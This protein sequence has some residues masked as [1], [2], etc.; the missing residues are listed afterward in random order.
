MHL[1]LADTHSSR[2]HVAGRHALH[3]RGPS[4][5]EKTP[6]EL[7]SRLTCLESLEIPGTCAQCTLKDVC[8]TSAALFL[9]FLFLLVQTCIVIVDAL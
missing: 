8:R 3:N 6:E 1:S 7:I 4:K 2:L 9:G 5:L